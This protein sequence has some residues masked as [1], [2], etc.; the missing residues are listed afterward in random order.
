MTQIQKYPVGWRVLHW[1]MALMVLTL[2]PIGLWMASRAEA[3]LWGELTD[4][5]YA[6]HKA[7]GFSVLLLMI[8][9]IVVKVRVKSPPYPDDMPRKLQMAAKG[10]HHLMYVLLV[11]TP[12]FGWAGVTAFPA[13][14]T[15]GG[16]DLPAMPFV[17]QNGY[18]A[19]T[20]FEIHG[21]LAIALAVLV[22]GHIAAAFRHM[23]RKDG[24]FRRMV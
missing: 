17:P 8:V 13:L 19:N 16:Y 5:L 22:L 23:L 2:I 15:L 12:L 4:T 10:L 21:A 7:I 3:D 6:W 24:I 18:L 1:V 11:L 20:L 14:V 9:R